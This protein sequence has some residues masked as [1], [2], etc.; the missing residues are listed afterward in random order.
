EGIEIVAGRAV[1][2]AFLE[3]VVAFVADVLL[4]GLVAE[5]EVVA[6]ATEGFV[7]VLTG[8]DEVIAEAAED[9]VGAGPGLDDVVAV[10]VLALAV[11]AAVGNDVVAG[12]AAE[13]V[14]AVAAVD[15]IVAAVAPHRIVIGIAG[16]QDVVS[17]GAAEHDG[18]GILEGSGILQVVRIGPGRVGIVADDERRHLD[19][20]D[21]DAA[22]RVGAPVGPETGELLR[23]IDLERVGRR[24]EDE[25]GQVG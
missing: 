6:L 13:L 25:R 12:A 16:D 17:L 21:R 22:G 14:I 19:A 23:L 11:A 15:A 1:G 7:V 20:V 24:H 18:R 2:R 8:D 3:P 5:D 10:A 9:Q 4:V